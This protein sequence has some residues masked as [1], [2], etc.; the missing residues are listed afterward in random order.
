MLH[1]DLV[2]FSS[3]LRVLGCG[4]HD[5][6]NYALSAFGPMLLCNCHFFFNIDFF[7]LLVCLYLPS[8]RICQYIIPGICPLL[9]NFFKKG[10]TLNMM[11]S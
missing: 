11:D 6:W 3:S 9:S 4:P 7:F 10:N 5:A 8:L 2:I 1:G